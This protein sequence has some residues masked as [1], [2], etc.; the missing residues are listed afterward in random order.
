[1]NDF[2]K[3]ITYQTTKLQKKT[4]TGSE[5][6]TKTKTKYGN[7][8][9]KRNAEAWLITCGCHRPGGGWGYLM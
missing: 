1:M 2:K 5:M 9:R 6:K 3:N 7:E 4:K 8:I